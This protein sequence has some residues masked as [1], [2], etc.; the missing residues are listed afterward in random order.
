MYGV[1]VCGVY[2]QGLPGP[3]DAA[4]LETAG[5]NAGRVALTE[6]LDRGRVVVI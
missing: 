6:V 5:F 1:Y 2:A 4:F 3:R